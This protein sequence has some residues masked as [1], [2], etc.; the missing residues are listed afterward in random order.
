MK[1]VLIIIIPIVILSVAL[2]AVGSTFIFYTD[3]QGL[4]VSSKNSAQIYTDTDAW[5]FEEIEIQTDSSNIEF[6]TAD[7]YG[8]EYMAND[9][10]DTTF[11]NEDG[12]LTIT[13]SSKA[14]LFNFNLAGK[15]DYIKIYLPTKANMKNVIIHD[16]SGN[17]T[18]AQLTT[19]NLDINVISGN[20]EFEN[21]QASLVSIDNTSGNIA[22]NDCKTD[23]MNITLISGQLGAK[24]LETGGMKINV[25]SGNVELTGKL[26]GTNEL[27]S[28]SGNVTLNITGE[29]NAYNS[30]ISVV[31]GNV[32]VDG[33]R[34][35]TYEYENADAANS[36][37]INV[38]S[39]NVTV[40]FDN[41]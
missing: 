20:A 2:F 8:F 7:R 32:T 12:K 18:I 19:E 1:K 25:T 13:Q 23:S 21:I 31:S 22:M 27:S 3:E 15:S 36:L 37:K 38:T 5:K 39:G 10:V 28:V 11:S 4:H 29:K 16:N 26:A 33:N 41:Q 24:N 14:L 34:T 40:N 17:I 35:N 30:N 9:A 6:I